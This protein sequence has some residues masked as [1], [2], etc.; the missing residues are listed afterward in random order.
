MWEFVVCVLVVGFC[1][2]VFGD[3]FVDFCF[4]ILVVVCCLMFARWFYVFGC[5]ILVFGFLLLYRGC[6]CLVFGV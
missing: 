4:L 6:W 2:L 1:V 3:W 5:L